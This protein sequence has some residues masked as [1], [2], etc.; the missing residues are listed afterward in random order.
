M[1]YEQAI[2]G[3]AKIWEVVEFPDEVKII[4]IKHSSNFFIDVGEKNKVASFPRVLMSKYQ[5]KH[6]LEVYEKNLSARGGLTAETQRR[7]E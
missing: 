5:I 6:Y 7:K 4:R 2:N 1:T 3:R